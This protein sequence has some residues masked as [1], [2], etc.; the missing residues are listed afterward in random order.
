[1]IAL[2]ESQVVGLWKYMTKKYGTVVVSKARADEMQAAAA[3][4][5]LMG[6]MDAKTFLSEYTTT[7]GKR[8]YVPFEVGN[9]SDCSLYSQVQ[10]CVHEHVHVRQFKDDKAL[11][12]LQYCLDSSKRASFECE[13]YVASMEMIFQITDVC[14]SPAKTASLLKAYGCNKSDVNVAAVYLKAAS[15]VIKKGGVITPESKIALSWL[16]KNVL[17]TRS[18]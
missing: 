5:A 18:R 11:F 10:I 9:A 3:A 7:I 2:T 17:K 13:A 16:H 14:P 8:I 6:I 1:M 15:S 12:F 4:L